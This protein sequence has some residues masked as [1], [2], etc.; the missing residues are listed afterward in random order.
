MNSKQK[1]KMGQG[2][3]PYYGLDHDS[4]HGVSRHYNVNGRTLIIDTKRNVVSH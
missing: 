1:K 4:Q 3:M 2:V